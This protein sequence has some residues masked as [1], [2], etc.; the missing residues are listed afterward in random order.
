LLN[1]KLLTYN[2]KTMEFRRINISKDTNC[3]ICGETPTITKLIDYDL[4]VCG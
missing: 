1:G 3:S 4:N 2:A